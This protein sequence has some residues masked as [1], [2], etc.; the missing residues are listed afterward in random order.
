MSNEKIYNLI[1]FPHAGAGASVY[2]EWKEVANN[3]NVIPAQLPGR[4][5]KFTEKPYTNINEA[6]DGL[7][8]EITKEI[9]AK[10]P[11]VIFGH[12]LGS[13]LAYELS[14]RLIGI[15]D[16]KVM[17]LVISG[18]SGPNNKRNKILNCHSDNEFIKNI[19]DITGY[20][21]P[22]LENP[23]MRSLILPVLK[24]DVQMNNSYIPTHK[25]A[26]IPITTIR[27]ENDQLVSFEEISEWQEVSTAPI[28]H[29]ELPGD[30]MYML[31][32]AN[33]IIS[34]IT[35]SINNLAT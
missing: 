35:E 14:H 16:Y 27:G 22:A 19:E 21:H 23:A 26:F 7:F 9:D 1:C 34:I 29:N 24:A 13:L 6:V 11:I 8:V 30:H 15:P 10:L 25:D 31:D 32:S 3:I 20:K 28:N 18:C 17:R 5:K 12:C 33:E 2:N 4:E